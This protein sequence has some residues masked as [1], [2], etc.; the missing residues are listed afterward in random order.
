MDSVVAVASGGPPSPDDNLAGR[1]AIELVGQHWVELTRLLAGWLGQGFSEDDSWPQQIAVVMMVRYGNGRGDLVEHLRRHPDAGPETA[2]RIL[3]RDA[4]RMRREVIRLV[5]REREKRQSHG[6]L[7]DHADSST[8]TGGYDP[9]AALDAQTDWYTDVDPEEVLVEAA[10][11]AFVAAIGTR[12]TRGE[13][14]WNQLRDDGVLDR[15]EWTDGEK[16]TAIAMMWDFTIEQIGVIRA[17]QAGRGR[18]GV[19]VPTRAATRTMMSEV[20]RKG[21]IIFEAMSPELRLAHGLRAGH[22]AGE[23]SGASP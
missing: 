13:Q 4:R 2:K 14:A 18:R 15:S 6:E 21:R 20:R 23:T 11:E 3:L 8:P 5:V 10:P 9:L 1:R 17:V 22:R 19:V 16:W 7:T 12:L